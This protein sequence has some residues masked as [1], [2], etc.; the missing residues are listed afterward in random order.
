MAELEV[1]PASR[2]SVTMGWVICA[3][4]AVFYCYEYLLRIEPSVMVPELMRKFQLSAEEFGFLTSLYY[5]AYTPMQIAVGLLTDIFGPR[6]MLTAAVLI[7]ALGSLLFGST[8]VVWLAGT[9]RFMVGFGSA[10][11]F[12]GVLKLAG[13]WLPSSR[14]ALFA[15]LATA[16]GM[17]GAMMGVVQLSSLVSNIG[18]ESTVFIGTVIGFI[19]VPIIWLVIRDTHGDSH[20]MDPIERVT[21]KEALRGVWSIAK[22]GQ[23]WYCGIIGL[24]LYMSLSVFGELW[25]VDFMQKTYGYTAREASFANALIFGGWLVGAPLVGWFSDVLRSRR[26]PLIIGCIASGLCFVTLLYFPPQSL[27]IVYLLMFFF[28]FFSSAEIVCFAIGRENCPFHMSGSAVSFV[29]MLVMFGGM[30][31]SPLVGKLL[32]KTWT[33]AMSD[34]LR[35][36][37]ADNYR[38]ALVMIPLSLLIGLIL[39]LLM[40]ESYGAGEEG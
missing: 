5:V 37:T 14:F 36:Y 9:G 24:A 30:L 26:I 22:N 3:L 31:F 40:R 25:G 12:V 39:T 17:V 34:G 13:I 15:G 29:N 6:K 4:G 20:Y 35:L 38:T 32:D 27:E 21:F 1:S 7:C 19:L 28:G 8:D 18:W 10:F 33:G 16:L 11:A 2:R 23:M